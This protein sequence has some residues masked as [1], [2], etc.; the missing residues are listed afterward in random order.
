MDW[1]IFMKN[2]EYISDV[3]LFVVIP[4]FYRRNR[5]RILYDVLRSLSSFPVGALRCV[6][7]TNE[8]EERSL[9]PLKDIAEFLFREEGVFEIISVPPEV[10]G[11]NRFGL[12]W[13]H[14][15]LLLTEF[16]KNANFTHFLYVEDDVE[17]RVD[18]LLYFLR[19]R[20]G[21][22]ALGL[23]PG[24]IR[25][26][27][28]NS[29]DAIFSSDFVTV[30]NVVKSAQVNIEGQLFVCP[31]CPYSAMYIFDQELAE[32]HINS[33]AF[34]EAASKTISDWGYAERA[35]AGLTW[36]KP[37]KGFRFRVVLPISSNKFVPRRMCCIFHIPSN[38]TNST[39]PQM[40]VGRFR[41]D[42]ILG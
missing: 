42:E 30:Q 1:W 32:E 41:I 18:N 33:P 29:L 24:F 21:L 28:N 13:Y 14:K 36:V 16:Y 9:K 26:E 12:T 3:E 5:L 2:I 10:V 20:E 27:Y 15:K 6:V 40:R 38:Y 25:I 22:G 37:P 4:F 7:I 17:V 35:V 8:K 39:Y 34:D 31:N 19:Y 11:S 23:I